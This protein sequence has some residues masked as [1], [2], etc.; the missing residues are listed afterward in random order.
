MTR[1][2]IISAIDVG[3]TKIAVLIGQKNE[4][5]S[6]INII[7]AASIPSLGIRKGQIVDIEQAS[8]T[9]IKAVEAAE[10]MAGL[11]VA[12]ILV[13]VGGAHIASQNSHGV[14]AVAEPEGEIVDEDIK[15][16]I[17]AARA[18]SLPSSREILHVIPRTFT[19]DSQ[20][21]V[22]DPVGMS[23]V[24]LEVETH[25]ITGSTTAIKNLTKCI[26]EVGA[27]V[28]SLVYEG[29]ASSEAVL[30][31]TEK[32][33]GVILLDI[34]GGTTS[35]VVL[36]ENAPAY[37]AVLP[38][39]ARNVTNDLA[40]GLRLSLDGAEKLKIAL[41]KERQAEET[42]KPN[43]DEI[44]LAKIGIYEETKK[45]SRK[46]LIEG[47][48]RPRLNEIFDMVAAEIQKS[49]FA[50]LTPSGVVLTGGGALTIGAAE[51]CRRCL[52]LPVRIGV[53]DEVSGLIDDILSPA[54]SAAIGLLFFGFKTKTE[55]ESG[56]ALTRLSSMAHKVPIR[57]LV[58]RVGSFIRS[59]LP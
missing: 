8:E 20:Q 55:K 25:I 36:V 21:G 11:S 52:S 35:I 45:V 37:T 22:A 44:D 50:G 27:T 38:I 39:G 19:V 31:Q 56:F 51:S 29:I 43:E 6:K 18:I 30:T 26:A 2:K 24:R 32:E 46:T 28:D 47:I 34:G 42:E 59:F 3:S 53:P 33:L 9:I 7:G 58:G 41:S 5:S 13:S 10:R 12:K 57:G 48:I 17:E 54:F 40:I 49:G 1:S 4:E 14:V 16:A 15:R 23:G